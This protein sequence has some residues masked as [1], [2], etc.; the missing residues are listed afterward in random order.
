MTQTLSVKYT[1]FWSS[2][3]RRVAR[4]LNEIESAFNDDDDSE[5][6]FTYESW[7][8]T[9]SKLSESDQHFTDSGSEAASS[10]KYYGKNIFKWPF[11]KLQWS[12]RIPA[13]NIV[14]F[15]GLQTYGKLNKTI[16]QKHVWKLLFTDEVLGIIVKRTNVKIE[17]KWCNFTDTNKIETANTN[18][19]ELR[20]ILSLLIC[21]FSSL[22]M[23]TFLC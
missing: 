1:V 22:A 21:L 20:S 5:E 16:D 2:L 11:I 14:H 3:C 9:N 19:E 7:H 8:S 23:K 4:I 6:N 10:T 13:H 15:P 18:I 17:K 12:I